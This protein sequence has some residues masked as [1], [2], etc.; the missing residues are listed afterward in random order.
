VLLGG[1]ITIFGVTFGGAAPV[2]A[3]GILVG[4]FL[5]GSAFVTEVAAVG[6]I[7]KTCLAQ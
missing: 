4:G 2:S 6:L 7:Y 1:S 3:T 5:E